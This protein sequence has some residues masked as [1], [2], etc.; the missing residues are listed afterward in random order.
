[1]KKNATDIQ[2]NKVQVSVLCVVQGLGV[3]RSCR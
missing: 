3:T 2:L 1:L